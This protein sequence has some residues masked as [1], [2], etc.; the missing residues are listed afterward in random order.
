MNSE[1]RLSSKMRG[2]AFTAAVLGI[3]SFFV[4]PKI[5]RPYECGKSMLLLIK[6]VGSFDDTSVRLLD[7]RFFSLAR[8]S[9][10]SLS[11]W[12]AT[13]LKR[14]PQGSDFSRLE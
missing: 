10:L 14:S 1:E 7:L 6:G 4:S 13:S 3:L 9:R 2:A 8:N 11:E 12:L 5:G